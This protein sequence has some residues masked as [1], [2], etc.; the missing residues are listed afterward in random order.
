MSTAT[1]DRPITS[2]RTTS[3]R[4]AASESQIVTNHPTAKVRRTYTLD[5]NVAEYLDATDNAS[6]T[7]NSLLLEGMREKQRL[8]AFARLIEELEE[9]SGPPDPALVEEARKLY[10]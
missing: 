5:R 1:L 2:E 10:R 3:A 7:A 9:I 6:N 8:E 4:Q